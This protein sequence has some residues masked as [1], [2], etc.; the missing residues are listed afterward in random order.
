MAIENVVD[1]K[2]LG[3]LPVREE[4]YDFVVNVDRQQ[5][6]AVMAFQALL[7]DPQI[8]DHLQSLG[9]RMA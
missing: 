6:A 4:Q 1:Q 3:F 7:E 2:L 8:R 5:R 9:M